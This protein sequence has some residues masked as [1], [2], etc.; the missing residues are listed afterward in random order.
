ML[1]KNKEKVFH[2]LKYDKFCRDSDERLIANIWFNEFRDKVNS[3]VE[4]EAGYTKLLESLVDGV[5]SSPE[6]I[7]RV[8]RKLQEQHPELRGEKWKARH[9]AQETVKEE[10]RNF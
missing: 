8:R 4:P 9:R 3:E 6:S 7:V 2:Q 1:K 5:L 10:L